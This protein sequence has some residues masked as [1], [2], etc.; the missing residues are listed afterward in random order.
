MGA[1]YQPFSDGA[2]LFRGDQDEQLE[3]RSECPQPLVLAQQGTMSIT[4]VFDASLEMSVKDFQQ[5]NGLTAGGIVGPATWAKLPA[6]RER[7][8]PFRMARRALASRG[9][10]R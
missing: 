9:C 6:Y 10:S 2:A 7:R 8:Q 1:Y 4:G 5:S 3:R